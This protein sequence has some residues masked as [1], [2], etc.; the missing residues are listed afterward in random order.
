MNKKYSSQLHKQTPHVKCYFPITG[1]KNDIQ[2]D[3]MDMSNVSTMNKNIKFAL[4]AVDIFTRK[5]YVIPLKNKIM[6][7]ITESF[8][9]LLRQIKPNKITCDNGSEFTSGECV[10]LCNA[11]KI[12][13]DYVDISNHYISHVGNRLGIVDRY[14]QSLRSKIQRYCDEYNTNKYIDILG[15]LVDNLNNS[16]N[17]GIKC[18]PNEVNSMQIEQLMTEKLLNAITH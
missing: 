13:I 16:Y 4:V 12:E 3:L 10:K 15:K 5:G 6:K 2:I 7:S 1:H 8:T 14:I 17:S 11:E 18:V 9:K